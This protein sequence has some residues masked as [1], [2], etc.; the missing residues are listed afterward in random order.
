MRRTRQNWWDQVTSIRGFDEPEGE[1]A[2]NGGE[3]TETDEGKGDG[4]GKEGEGTE[5]K[6]SETDVAGLKS[7]L[8]K[9]RADR[10]KLDK[11]LKAF[12][13]AQQAKEDAEKTEVERLTGATTAQQQKLEKL[14]AGYRSNAVNQAI[15]KA[16]G[17]AKFLDPSDAL[18][19]EVI[20][21]AGVEQDED[22]PTEITIDEVTV[23]QAIKA[24][25]KS[26]PHWLSTGQEKKITPKSGST[27]GG[28]GTGGDDASAQL[29]AK[30][31]AF[32]RRVQ[33]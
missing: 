16:A 24:L 14:A 2:G 10:K 26:K 7:A 12:Q 11:D 9:E 28:S 13:K 27:F 6:Y 3:G 4:T 23:T 32:G 30:Y 19:P 17:A 18:R 21:A 29:A 25:A 20:A 33:S 5:V 1:G 22:D 15:L 8:E 31:P